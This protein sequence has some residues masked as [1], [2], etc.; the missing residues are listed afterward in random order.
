MIA[1][2]IEDFYMKGKHD[3]LAKSAFSH[4]TNRNERIAL[5]DGMLTVLHHQYVHSG[6]LA[7]R[8]FRVLEGSGMGNSHSGELADIHFL[9]HVEEPILLNQEIR[10][11]YGIYLYG[12]FRDDCL[13][14]MRDDEDLKKELLRKLQSKANNA[15][16]K[17]KKEGENDKKMNF[18]DLTVYCEYP[19]YWQTLKLSYTLYTKE[20]A[21]KVPLTP[22]S[23]HPKTV[24]RSWPMA[25]I[26]R[27]RKRCSGYFDFRRAK[28]RFLETLV[29]HNFD[30][31]LYEKVRNINPLIPKKRQADS[32]KNKLYWILPYHPALERSGLR[33]L[34][35]HVIEKWTI[36]E[37]DHV[38][39]C[40]A[41]KNS[42]TNLTSM[43]R[44][45]EKEC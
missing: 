23:S 22:N 1:L 32:G 16:Y 13:L 5:E 2:D 11:K 15:G 19:K 30:N 44:Y 29:Y 3:D 43:L 36:N 12:R 18:L 33:R 6:S 26:M 42:M 21:Q 45:F 39:I 9:K 17:L 14:I 4:I 27:Y 41:W 38:Q 8:Y 25:E 10:E 31:D 7:G 34:I 20:T 37:M 40:I 28:R 35:D 24:H